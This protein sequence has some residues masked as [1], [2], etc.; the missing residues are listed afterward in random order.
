MQRIPQKIWK[1]SDHVGLQYVHRKARVAIS[2]LHQLE[3]QNRNAD[4]KN[5]KNQLRPW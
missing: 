4:N 1:K 3:C 5:E 2:L